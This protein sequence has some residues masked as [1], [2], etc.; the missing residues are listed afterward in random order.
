MGCRK[1][2][3][4]NHSKGSGSLVNRSAN[5]VFGD[6]ARW[7]LI[8]HRVH[9]GNLGGVGSSVTGCRTGLYEGVIVG[10]DGEVRFWLMRGEEKGFK[11]IMVE[12][13]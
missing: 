10:L 9:E 6:P 12:L 1:H 11:G 7:V 13:R 5:E 8:E 4:T 2:C 3:R